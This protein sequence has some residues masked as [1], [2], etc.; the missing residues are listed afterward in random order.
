M[1]ASIL[2]F[3]MNALGRNLPGAFLAA[4]T[5]ASAVGFSVWLAHREHVDEHDWISAIV[6]TFAIT[7][8]F[9][10]E[11]FCNYYYPLAALLF[12]RALVAPIEPA[13]RTS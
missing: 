2:A 1:Q 12:A 6:M 3:T 10:K 8:L 7:F 11:A 9:G 4:V 13:G 5:I